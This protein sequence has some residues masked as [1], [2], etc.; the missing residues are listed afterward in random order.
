VGI[1]TEHDLA[2][3]A[4]DGGREAIGKGGRHVSRL[5]ISGRVI[6]ESSVVTNTAPA[7]IS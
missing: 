6:V 5:R 1:E 2:V 7:I 4:P 3:A